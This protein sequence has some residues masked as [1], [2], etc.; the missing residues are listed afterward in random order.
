MVTVAVVIFEP[1]ELSVPTLTRA[2]AK[3][4]GGDDP[5]GKLNKRASI[6]GGV[7]AGVE[8][9]PP[10][11]PH[12]NR[13]IETSRYTTVHAMIFLIFPSSLPE[14]GLKPDS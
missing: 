11:P 9:P 2:F 5:V 12:A 1:L 3:L 6:K 13:P 14:S 4:A 7:G 10:P 8:P